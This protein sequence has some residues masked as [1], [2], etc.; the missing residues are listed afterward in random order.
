[1]ELIGATQKAIM[2]SVTNAKNGHLL[3]DDLLFLI[4]LSPDPTAKK[5]AVSK[6]VDFLNV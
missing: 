5:L 6:S 2:G 1:M 3:N 4:Q